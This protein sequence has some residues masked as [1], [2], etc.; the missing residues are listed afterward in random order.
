MKYQNGDHFKIDGWSN[1][2]IGLGLKNKDKHLG[3]RIETGFLDRQTLEALYQSDDIT[4]F[5]PF[6]WI[7]E[8]IDEHA[9]FP[10]G[11]YEDQVDAYTQILTRIEKLK[12]L[13]SF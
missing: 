1:I 11:L 5:G 12:S 2:L 7:H 6:S 13:I 4:A 3:A 9:N 8:F 10:N